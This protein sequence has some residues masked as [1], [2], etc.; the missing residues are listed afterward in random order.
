[1][2]ASF[3]IWIK[4]CEEIE[5]GDEDYRAKGLQFATY[6]SGKAQFTLFNLLLLTY[7]LVEFTLLIGILIAGL[8]KVNLYHITF[9]FIFIGLLGFPNKKM[10]L[11]RLLIVYSTFF[12]MSKY[13]YT[14]LDQKSI[15]KDFD[16]LLGVIGIKTS[17]HDGDR[18]YFEYSFVTAQW[19]VLFVGC[20]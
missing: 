3:F 8:W 6:M 16:E 2:I 17:Y 10:F 5:P 9:L 7:P 15:S 14:L 19:N 4:F 11:T 13:V 18:L 1:M 12:L 20:I